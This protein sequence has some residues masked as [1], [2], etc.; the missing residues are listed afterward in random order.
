[1]EV[2]LLPIDAFN[3]TGRRVLLRVDINS[4]IDPVTRRIVDDNRI[5]RSLP[6]LRDLLDRGARLGI[7]AHQGDTL[8]YQNLIPLAEHAERLT[9]LLGRRVD[10]LD[11]VC[12]PAA[13]DRVRQLAPGDAVLLGNLRYLA[14]EVSGFEKEVKLAPE[15]MGSTWLVR[16]LAPLFDLY[17][18]DA[19]AAAHRNAPS[20]VAFQECLPTAAG[21]LLYEELGALAR[22]VRSPR[23]PV[24]FV[25]GG[26][27][28]S[29]A[30][31]MLREVLEKGIAD[32]VLVS[33]VVGQ[34]FLLASGHRIG[35]RVE[36]WLADRDLLPFVEQ[37]RACLAGWS[38][39]I[40]MP[41]DLVGTV[42]E[43]TGPVDVVAL[44][45]EDG[46]FADIGPATCA[47]FGAELA[48]AG[49]LFANG[50]AGVYETPPFDAGTRFLWQAIA[51]SPGFSVIGGG[52][53]V[54]S[55]RKFVGLERFGYVCTAGGAMVRFLSGKRLPLVEAMEKAFRRDRARLAEGGPT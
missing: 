16:S 32:R 47:A 35:R 55:A 7:L 8:D 39:R 25:L 53:T 12:G 26:A 9:A 34:V 40:R 44:P 41:L 29:D 19:F 6:T 42:G 17:V 46:W 2:N 24:V 5:R 21:R 38:D 51:D 50:P 3:V 22:L 31:G 14:E 1:M 10:Y 45:I 15:D 27:K 43:T 13:C 54:G 23:R 49:T 20:M 37:A 28:I 33:G 4:P 36:A 52:D 18:N 11:D 30:F 48:S